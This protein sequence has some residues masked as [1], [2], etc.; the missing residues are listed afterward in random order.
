MSESLHFIGFPEEPEPPRAAAPEWRDVWTKEADV[1]V[2]ALRLQIDAL[3]GCR[4]RDRG[5][6]VCPGRGV[7]YLLRGGWPFRVAQGYN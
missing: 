4:R 2:D 6:G 1:A 5:I 7:D 3:A